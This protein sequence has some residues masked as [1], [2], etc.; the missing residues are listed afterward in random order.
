MQTLEKWVVEIEQGLTQFLPPSATRPTK[1]HEAMHYSIFSGGKRIRPLLVLAVT[2]ALQQHRQD[3]LPAA[4]AVEFV[5]TYTLIHDD[6]P[7]MDNDSERRGKPTCHIQFDE[8][9]ALLAGD[10]LLTLAFETAAASPVNPQG[11]VTTL[12]RAAGSEGVI[13]GQVEDLAATNTQVSAD[14]L[15]FIHTHKTADLIA[16]ACRMG[17]IAAQANDQQTDQ[18][19]RYGHSLGMAFQ[20]VD[21]LLDAEEP[22]DHA[23]SAVDTL[24][25]CA[26]A[27]QAKSYTR[28]AYQELK[29]LS[30]CNTELLED[31]TNQLLKRK[32]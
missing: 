21:D 3:A 2:E 20:L 30:G 9:T 11:M 17:A 31:L 5:H 10:A 12:A 32:V 23:F 19:T 26:V 7:C 15:D 8:A 1:L 18:F 6:L 4:C 25:R 14:T 29:E 28:K 16:A 24:G 13:G 27:D 22:E